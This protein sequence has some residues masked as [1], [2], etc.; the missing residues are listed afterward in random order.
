VKLK[1][2]YLV[3]LFTIGASMDNLKSLSTD[4]F[5]GLDFM[6]YNQVTPLLCIDKNLLASK[7]LKIGLE[8]PIGILEEPP[9]EENIEHDSDEDRGDEPVE[10]ETIPKRKRVP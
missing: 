1:N 2:G 3:Q 9:L 5:P 10:D 7:A 6:L 4:I 8:F